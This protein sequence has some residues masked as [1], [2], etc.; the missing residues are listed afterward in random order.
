MKSLAKFLIS[1]VSSALLIG[2]AAPA[3]AAAPFLSV[4]PEGGTNSVR[5]TVTNADSYSQISLY[6]RQTTQLWTVINNF[7]QTDASG[8]FSQLANLG[9]DGS[10]NLVEQYVVVNGQQSSVVQTYPNGNGTCTYNC[11]Y[12]GLLSL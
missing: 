7:G 6:R 3:F 10:N 4:S 5:V 11:G 8:Y 9:A 2:V 12:P 1:V